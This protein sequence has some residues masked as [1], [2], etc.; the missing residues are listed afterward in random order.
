VV[1]EDIASWLMRPDAQL[2]SGADAAAERWLHEAVG[3]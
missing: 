2:P 1:A 3:R